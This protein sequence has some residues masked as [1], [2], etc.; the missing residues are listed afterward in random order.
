MS[1]FCFVGGLSRW[2]K[3][4]R[5][6]KWRRITHQW[7]HRE[8]QKKKKWNKENDAKRTRKEIINTWSSIIV[9]NGT[10]DKA[11]CGSIKYIRLHCRTTTTTATTTIIIT[12]ITTTT[13]KTRTTM[14]NEENKW[15]S[16]SKKR[17]TNTGDLMRWNTKRET[18]NRTDWILLVLYHMFECICLLAH[19]TIHIYEF[20]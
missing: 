18:I 13:M 9:Y 8:N 5:R 3:K 6:K 11:E 1:Y 14:T 10:R 17:K 7:Q 12:T 20:V 19:N 4:R 15:T 16:S 2:R